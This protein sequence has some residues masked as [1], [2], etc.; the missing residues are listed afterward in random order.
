MRRY[1]WWALWLILWAFFAH[2]LFIA[3]ATSMTID[4]GL[5]IASGYTIWRTGDYRLIEEH[6]PAVKLWLAIPVLPLA[7]L[8]DPTELPAWEEAAT[9]ERTE[10]LPLLHMAQQLLYPSLPVDRWLIPA[11]A[12]SALLGCLLLAVILRWARE[13]VGIKMG[14]AATLLASLDPNLLAHSA[15]AGTDLGTTTLILWTL[16]EATRWFRRPTLSHAVRLG[17]LLGLALAAKLT[18][19]TLLPA[20][21]IVGMTHLLLPRRTGLGRWQF[22][23]LSSTVLAVCALVFWAAY[24]F[25]VGRLPGLP[26]PVPAAAHAIPVSRLLSHS[27][28]G[29]QAYLLGENSDHG[30]WSY[31]PL[32]FLLKT[33]IPLLLILAGGALHWIREIVDR[34]SWVQW[35]LSIPALFAMTYGVI[36]LLSTLNIGYRHLLPLV[37]LG[38]IGG[39]SALTSLARKETAVPH[40]WVGSVTALLVAIQMGSVL[41]LSPY[42]L[43]Y[44][45]EL[46]GGPRQG[47]RYLADSNTD[48]GQGYK[49]L[50]QF[51]DERHIDHVKLAAFIFYD[52]AVYGVRYEPLTPL[53][54]DTP[55]VFPSRFAP[56]PGDYVISMTPLDGIPLV[57]GEMYDWFR[58]R[59]PDALIAHALHFYHV[60]PEEVETDW[61]AQCAVPVVPLD[62]QALT[63]GL[64]APPE[65][66]LPFD[67]TQTWVI[68]GGRDG[69]GMYVL[70]GALVKDTLAAR[71]HY[72]APPLTHAFTARHLEKA[73]LIYRQRAYRA[74]PAFV[75]YRSSDNT[76]TPAPLKVWAQPGG[77]AMPP[78]DHTATVNTPLALDGPADLI[79]VQ[80]IALKEA[81]EV[82]TWWRITEGPI[83]RPFSVMGHFLTSDGKALQVSDGLGISPEM[84]Q[85]GDL[86]IQLHRFTLR[87]EERPTYFRTGLYWLDTME[88]WSMVQRPE[89]DTFTIPLSKA[90][91]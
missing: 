49:A 72:A 31:F 54:G 11:R 38:Y 2:V 5:H 4:E 10:S 82:E 85:P 14:L 51:Q 28:G 63:E 59:M 50:A 67:C 73:R 48:W 55:P 69:P 76:E 33:P 30:W 34:R 79:S 90:A 26:L 88:R 47:W 58:W 75:L 39:A 16:W 64:G 84:L 37:P 20:M 71:L 35:L 81:L 91:P 87:E 40:R 56:P 15:I 12:M 70:H 8:P 19:L 89:A 6:P 53:R 13:R 46:V 22:I 1:K 61:V 65:R 57:D 41:S 36:S 23:R 43:S 78:F 27:A 42:L 52:P 62:A 29:H 83:T 66:S 80:V 17:I 9:T 24:G 18:A 74:E 7:G 21:A 32:A 45:N 44:F 3:R 86:L 60:T 77:V 68:P 25:Q